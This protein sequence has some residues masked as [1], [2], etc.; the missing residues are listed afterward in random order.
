MDA[1]AH[2]LALSVG[3]ARAGAKRS[4]ARSDAAPTAGQRAR[5][6]LGRTR[7]RATEAQKPG[8]AMDVQTREVESGTE[9]DDGGARRLWFADYEEA[10]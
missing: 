7:S 8:G 5:P 1:C 3:P 4:A 10:E 2:R 9:R 6:N